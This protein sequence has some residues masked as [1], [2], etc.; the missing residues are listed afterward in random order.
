MDY[1]D[2][3]TKQKKPT[4]YSWQEKALKGDG[5]YKQRIQEAIAKDSRSKGIQKT[6]NAEW[7]NNAATKG[8]QRWAPGVS[9]AEGDYR[10][11]IGA[12]LTV[13]ESVTLP[14]RVSDP[15]QN[16]AARVTPIAVALRA[17]KDEGRL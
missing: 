9:A 13:I 16:V 14:D 1:L 6:S 10:K 4:T 11:G 5:L 7:Q 8:A 15:A 3:I 12:V 2:N 17:A